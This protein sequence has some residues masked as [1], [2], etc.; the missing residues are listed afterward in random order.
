MN[1]LEESIQVKEDKKG[2]KAPTILLI[3]ICLVV[4]IIISI[5][6]YLSYIKSNSLHLNLDG[7]PNNDIKKLLVF[8]EDGSIYVPIKEVAKY[9]QYESYNGEY[10][11]ASEEISRCYVQNDSEIANLSLGTKKIYKLDITK[12]SNSEYEMIEIDKPIKA[13][14]GVLY[15]TTDAMEKVFNVSYIYDQNTNSIDI[16]TLPYLINFYENRILDYGYVELSK[17]YTNNKAILKDILIVKKDHEKNKYG[18]IDVEGNI[19]LEP[20]YDNITYQYN[21]GNFLVKSNEKYGIIGSNTQTKVP[22]IYT[23]LEI[24]DNQTG[25]YIVK[26]ER[27]QCGV[28][29]SNG[30]IKISI[31]N[32]EIGIDI[33]KFKENNIKSKYILVDDLIPVRKD[34]YWGLY[35]KN[36]N[37]VTE[38][39]YDNFG[40]I[41]NSNK[42]TLNLLVIPEYNVL[43]ACKDKKYTLVN[44]IGEKIFAVI[45]DDIYMT[46]TNQEKHYY[47]NVNNRQIDAE[48]YLDKKGISKKENSESNSK[49]EE[50]STNEI[51]QNESNENKSNSQTTNQNQ[52]NSNK[53]NQVNTNKNVNEKNQN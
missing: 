26:N 43:V 52:S 14:N 35:N 15:M 50:K 44:S 51:N 41:A 42:N 36:G 37:Q 11:N 13:I 47:I 17:E 23:N 19:I 46:I 32:D 4:L 25:L 33:S 9:F 29:D 3:T 24:L 27:N 16:Y 20:K 30:N 48:Q 38:Y 40:Y 49:N 1:L 28:I 5:V 18:A 45:A 53:S 12:K 8:E 22:I 21:T 31:E 2:K 34:K 6:V 10:N 7:V 39:E